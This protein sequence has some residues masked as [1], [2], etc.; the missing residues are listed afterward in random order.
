MTA[1]LSF[2]T[3][4]NP[5]ARSVVKPGP[6]RPAVSQPHPSLYG[7]KFKYLNTQFSYPRNWK[8]LISEK[9]ICFT[10]I[11]DWL[12]WIRI[13]FYQSTAFLKAFIEQA[14]HNVRLLLQNIY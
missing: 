5:C 1:L 3:S 6:A 2:M 7:R 12:T 13:F 4:G 14:Y 11:P 9:L 8:K 10:A